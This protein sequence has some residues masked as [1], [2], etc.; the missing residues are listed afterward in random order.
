MLSCMLLATDPEM[1]IEV[2]HVPTA[3]QKAD[4]FT[5][6]LEPA[7]FLKA[8]AMLGMKHMFDMKIF[9]RHD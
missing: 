6:A 5:K 4:I 1:M 7:A 2:E 9:L 8:V 3:E